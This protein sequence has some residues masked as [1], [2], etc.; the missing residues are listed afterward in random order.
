MNRSP[1]TYSTGQKALHWTMALII[2]LMVPVGILMADVLSDGAVKN[3][4]YELHKSFGIVVFSLALIRILLRLA[5]GAPPLVPGL[6]AWQRTAAYG[7]HYAMYILVVVVPLTGWA[8]TSA[9]CP[10]VNVFWTLPV[11][12]PVSGGMERAEAIFVFHR[13]FALTLAGIVLIHASAALHHHFV[14]RDRT[15]RR[16]LPGG[17]GAGDGQD[18]RMPDGARDA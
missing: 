17:S 15:L 13:T 3:T 18:V 6:P 11:T 8:A 1:D 14:R 5:R 7:S 16:M 12:L 9:C 10:P 2:V 4:L